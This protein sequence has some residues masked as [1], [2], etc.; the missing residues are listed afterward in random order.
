M[1]RTIGSV[2]DVAQSSE[3]SRESP[4]MSATGRSGVVRRVAELLSAE[5]PVADL[6]GRCCEQL[7][8]LCDAKIATIAMCGVH[9]ERIVY[10]FEQ[11]QAGPCTGSTIAPDSVLAQVFSSSETVV[12]NDPP[13][14]A[15]G[16]PVRFGR[17]LL[18]ALCVEGIAVYDPELVTLL[19][20]CALYVA[21]RI[22]YESVLQSSERYEEL[23]LSDGL[24]GI[25]NRRRFDEAL[26]SEWRR[27]TRERKPLTLLMIDV[28]F[29]KLFNDHYGHEAGDVC[30]KQIARLIEETVKRPADLIARYGGEE[31]VVLLPGTDQSGGVAIA[32]RLVACVSDL[33][34]PHAA[35][36][37]GHVTVSIGIAAA[38]PT[39]QTSADVVLR[40]ADRALYEAKHSGRNR[41]VT[42]VVRE[43]LPT[44]STPFIGRTS[45]IADLTHFLAAHHLVT[46]TGSGGA[47]K[48]RVALQVA[49]E[50]TERFEDGTWFVDLAELSD[51]GSIAAAISTAISEDIPEGA[52]VAGLAR[53][54][55]TKRALLILDT[56]EHLVQPVA[57]VVVTLLRACPHLRILATSRE[58]LGILGEAIYR[59][60]LLALPGPGD[61]TAEAIAQAEA[62]ALFVDRA[63]A[64]QP[65]FD[66]AHNA[67]LV[68]DICRQIEGLPLAIEFAAAQLAVLELEPLSKLLSQAL[69]AS[70]RRTGPQRQRTLG[71]LIDWSYADLPE[72][73][74]TLFRRL[75]VFPANWTLDAATEICAIDGIDPDDIFDLVSALIRKSLVIDELVGE[76]SRYRLLGVSREYARDKL[77]AAGELRRLVARHAASYHRAV[78]G[79]EPDTRV[80]GRGVSALGVGLEGGAGVLRAIP[81]P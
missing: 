9:G 45:E 68:A 30:L 77:A 29:F 49:R 53:A 15:I 47:G 21:A 36:P 14:C 60:S 10:A 61:L 79:N 70:S 26:A 19:E 72:K 64:V 4:L 28:D 48:T 43:N 2:Q 24:T 40:A 23:A 62:V 50:L 75:S 67:E 37:L 80:P 1:E 7:L 38:V 74:R 71:A 3:P 65:D 12:R 34:M 73:E 69:A 6:W 76:D 18:G 41:L 35:S 22:D 51:P 58:E 57:E 27:L 42:S 16:V 31:F 46:I 63:Q 59:L 54:M 20:S 78:Q 11:G 8:A 66:L 25:A 17:V 33:S 5:T 44:P 52:A 39:A 81:V 13:V 56:C 32:E 55:E